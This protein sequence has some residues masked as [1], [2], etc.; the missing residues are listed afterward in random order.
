MS[1]YERVPFNGGVYYY[2]GDLPVVITG[3]YSN[4]E[5]ESDCVSWHVSTTNEY[6]HSLGEAHESIEHMIT[7]SN[8]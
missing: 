6:F 3:T 5:F 1:T 4:N 8:P 2:F 7:L